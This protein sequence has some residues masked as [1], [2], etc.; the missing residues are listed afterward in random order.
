MKN[1]PKRLVKSVLITLGFTS[2]TSAT[3]TA[4]QKEIFGSVITTLIISNEE[5][6]D[7]VKKLDLLENLVYW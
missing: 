7:V 5:M 6:D 2:A 3:D 1:V 4:I